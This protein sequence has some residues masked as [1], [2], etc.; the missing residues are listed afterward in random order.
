MFLITLNTG[1]VQNVDRKELVPE[2]LASLHHIAHGGKLPVHGFSLTLHRLSGASRGATG[3]SLIHNNLGA[4][5]WLVAIQC[6]DREISSTAWNSAEQAFFNVTDSNPAIFA[7][8]KE[9]ATEP[10]TVP[11]LALIHFPALIAVNDPKT[12]RKIDEVATHLA[13]ATMDDATK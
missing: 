10:D 9:L 12:L 6:W 7:G 8:H 11:W 4:K 5:I 1:A 3:W 13:F 2:F